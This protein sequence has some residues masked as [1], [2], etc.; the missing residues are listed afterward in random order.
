MRALSNREFVLLT[1]IGMLLTIFFRA[2]V[3]SPILFSVGCLI[4]LSVLGLIVFC[5]L[6]LIIYPLLVLM[7]SMPDLTQIEEDIAA[8]GALMSATA[9]QFKVG[10]FTPALIIAL[11]LIIA[12]VRLYRGTIRREYIALCLYLCLVVPI[13]SICNSFAFESP[14]RFI[15]DAKIPIYLC[16]GLLLFSYYYGRFPGELVASSQFFVSLVIGVFCLDAFKLI[17]QGSETESL[18]NYVNL[19]LDSGK[20]LVTVIIFLA[21]A[22]ISERRSII[23]SFCAIGL[24]LL[25]LMAYQTRWLLVTLSLGVFFV[26][27]LLGLK[28]AIALSLSVGLFLFV[29]TPILIGYFPEVWRIAQIRLSFLGEITAHVSLLD[30]EP[31]RT[32]S[33]YNSV[34]LLWDKWAIFTGMGYGSWYSDAYLQMPPLTLSAFD[35][36]S[37]ISGKYYR[38]HDFIFHFLFKF[39]LIG[40]LIYVTTFIKPVFN[41]WQCRKYIF[42]QRLHREVAI[43]SIGIMPMVITYM[44]FS[45][46]GLLFSAWFVVASSE[47]ATVFVNTIPAND[48]KLP[49]KDLLGVNGTIC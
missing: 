6:R 2:D 30:V 39:G 23:L 42:C 18:D 37:L 17:F 1:A 11:F 29:A 5:P 35:Q 32:A 45:G 47:W 36:D 3:R 38:V 20:G 16:T 44:W 49:S 24:G 12:F 34:R 19:S 41:I 10:A 31:A 27:A 26:I 21:I 14:A 15:T 33:I 8:T 7:V 40:L 48:T 9:W 43:I 13:I 25:V 4:A 22:R 46:K 28:R